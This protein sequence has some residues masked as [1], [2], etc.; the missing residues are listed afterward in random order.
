MKF[1]GFL[2][3]ALAG[4]VGMGMALI[5]PSLTV[6]AQQN[7]T[8]L[9][10]EA[11]SLASTG[12]QTNILPTASSCFVIA[13]HDSRAELVQVECPD[14]EPTF[15]SALTVTPT[16]IIQPSAAPATA[17]PTAT[18]TPGGLGTA[19]TPTKVT[20]TPAPTATYNGLC[21]WVLQGAD[22]YQ[23]KGQGYYYYTDPQ[24]TGIPKQNIR[25]GPGTTY[26]IVG[27]LPKNEARLVWF[28]IQLGDQVWVAF[29]ETCSQWAA[30]WL[31]YIDIHP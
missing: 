28:E 1:S 10:V 19:A 29:N 21:Q 8:R 22:W 13:A 12:P 2:S 31:G 4:A 17:I 14:S 24:G 15:P 6:P 23:P 9:V 27:Q 26:S 11:Q 7:P 3:H 25:S 30:V 20:G 16:P 5:L 18:P